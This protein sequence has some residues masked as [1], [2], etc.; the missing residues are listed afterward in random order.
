[1][2]STEHN[3]TISLDPNAV[4]CVILD[5]AFGNSRANTRFAVGHSGGIALY[6]RARFKGYRCQALSDSAGGSVG[7]SVGVRG[8]AVRGGA[9]TGNVLAW[10]TDTGV[11]VY[12]MILRTT[13]ALIPRDHSAAL[14]SVQF[15]PQLK[16]QSQDRLLIGWADSI[17][18]CCIK[19]R[20]QGTSS[21]RSS[22]TSSPN[23]GTSSRHSESPLANKLLCS[24][25]ETDSAQIASFSPYDSGSRKYS[26]SVLTPRPGALA[27]GSA[28]RSPQ[29]PTEALP[30]TPEGISSYL[31][32]SIIA[33]TG[34]NGRI[35]PPSTPSF[36]LPP[37]YVEIESMFTTPFYI[38]GIGM[39]ED[40]II[41]LTYSKTPT[42]ES[43]RASPTDTKGPQQFTDDPHEWRRPQLRL[44][45]PQQRSYDEIS[46]DILG[47]NRY[48]EYL[49]LHYKL[50]C[51]AG[52]DRWYVLS[53]RDLVVAK[54][55]E[56][57]DSL[58][59]LIEH[60]KYPQAL[61]LIEREGGTI[62]DHT[63]A[64]VGR[65]Y[66]NH[67]LECHMYDDAARISQRVIRDNVGEWLELVRAFAD[68][69]ELRILHEYLPHG[70]PPPLPV[71]TYNEV[72]MDLLDHNREGLVAA[73]QKW[74]SSCYDVNWLVS[75]VLQ[76]VAT[77]NWSVPLLQSLAHLY[78]HQQR[79][80]KAL[81]IYI[82]LEHKDI[83]GLIK[84]HGLYSTIGTYAVHLM[85]L[86]ADLTTE[87][88]M[89][90]I[91]DAP[92]T[93]MVPA[94]SSTPNLL[95]KY[96]TAL[97]KK[98]EDLCKPYHDDLVQLMADNQQSEKLL[99]FLK[100]SNSYNLSA[101]LRVCKDRGL[102]HHTVYLLNRTGNT[103]DALSLV[104]LEARDLNWAIDL[105]KHHNDRHLWDTLIDHTISYSDNIRPLL[106]EAGK[107][108][109]EVEILRK[110]PPGL[111]VPGLMASISKIMED[112]RKKLALHS[113][114]ERLC[115]RDI[116]HL[117]E[118]RRR[119]ATRAISIDEQ[120][121]CPRCEKSVIGKQAKNL[122]GLVAFRCGHVFHSDCLTSSNEIA[123]SFPANNTGRKRER[124]KPLPTLVCVVC[125]LKNQL[126][127]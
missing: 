55:R 82:K 9:W 43:S 84:K 42:L 69:G 6:E 121:S 68:A 100:A 26:S 78:S 89:T 39:L 113:G 27:T 73:L 109:G 115:K 92:P 28:L 74:P 67:L 33:I 81:A 65:Q 123:A 101:A 63:E 88:C 23:I 30:S 58:E 18:V 22:R 29:F 15:P 95:Y 17:K 50:E 13:I 53:P 76:R 122:G 116:V 31:S 96:L 70:S 5:P 97:H 105:C 77:Q 40:L 1:M 80:D 11:R 45:E 87:L 59:W 44:L 35:T 64:S 120:T 114:C 41:T 19:P 20:P 83:F 94:L 98:H 14:D 107:Y 110:I 54:P 102:L 61:H 38:C 127:R 103:Q 8:G 48:K 104:L 57:S 12:H 51:V 72:L 117:N 86:D 25:S 4:H 60:H 91:S 10:A 75:A 112:T 85:T 3:E 119:L 126:F 62:G 24:V 32:S 125:L 46:K 37:L 108:V 118:R 99:Q 124:C 106:E 93:E 16:W 7:A 52:G 90:H 66:L 2:L 36:D 111:E 49:P 79:H 56:P 47:T 21:C 34:G 71:T